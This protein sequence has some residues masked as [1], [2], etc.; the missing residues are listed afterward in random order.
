MLLQI[1]TA[2]FLYEMKTWYNDNVFHERFFVW[3]A[4]KIK[5]NESNFEI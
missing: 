3:L 1:V 2:P 4:E 5:Q